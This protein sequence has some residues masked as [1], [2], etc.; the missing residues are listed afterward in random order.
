MEI[1]VL[2]NSCRIGT[3]EYRVHT[4]FPNWVIQGGVVCHVL[5]AVTAVSSLID[6]N[7]DMPMS[8]DNGIFKRALQHKY[9]T[10]PVVDGGCQR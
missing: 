5:A 3:M 10:L 4:C 7:A 1:R 9:R 2:S 8:T 6:F